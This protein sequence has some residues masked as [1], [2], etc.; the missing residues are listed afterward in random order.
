MSTST[1][2]T[3]IVILTF[4]WG[5]FTFALMTAIRSEG[6]KTEGDVAEAD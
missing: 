1:W 4:V 5:G 3:M 6:A 2:I